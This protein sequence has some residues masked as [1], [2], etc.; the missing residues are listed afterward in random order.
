MSMDGKNRTVIIN[1]NKRHEYD[2]VLSLTLDYEAQMLYWI[3][4][5]FHNSSLHIE[6][7]NTNGMNRQTVIHLPHTY[8]R[9]SLHQ[10]PGLTMNEDMLYLSSLYHNNEAYKLRTSGENF[11]TFIDRSTLFMFQPYQL[12][13]AKHQP[14]G[15]Y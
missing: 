3:F 11:T 14:P 15:Y 13:V 6:R 5:N 12:K 7:S 4:G 2:A 1:V 9:N 10:P 8:N